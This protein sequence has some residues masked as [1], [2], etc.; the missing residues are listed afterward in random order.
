MSLSQIEKDEILTDILQDL[1]NT[2]YACHTITPLSG[3]T[4]NF[5]FRGTLDDDKTVIIKHSTNF[6]SINKNFPFDIS[7]CVRPCSLRPRTRANDQIVE[8]TMLKSLSDFYHAVKTP[9]LLLFQERTHT[10]IHEDFP[11]AVD[12]KSLVLSTSLLKVNATSI[13]HQLGNWLRSFH[14]WSSTQTLPENLPMQRLKLEVTHES[15][16]GILEKFPHV[17]G[18]NK[19]VLEMVRNSE[20]QEIHDPPESWITIHGDFWAGK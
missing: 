15:F 20:I 11:R 7:R 18:E 5:V 14:A 4:A 9:R 2:P 10:Q 12:L 3:G 8:Q 19:E 16:I 13:G 6:T 1:F 17:L